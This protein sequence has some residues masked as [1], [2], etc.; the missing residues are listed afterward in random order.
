MR[1]LAC[2]GTLL[3]GLAI[4]VS[5]LEA[6]SDSSPAP[7]PATPAPPADVLAV[8]AGGRLV[9]ELDRSLHT[10]HNRQGDP[11][12]F[13]ISEEILV[14]YQVAVPR[15]ST[16]RATLTEVKRPGRLAGRAEI[17]LQFD[18]IELPD[19]TRLPFAA[20]ILRAGFSQIGKDK[21]RLS[22]KGEGNKGRDLTTIGMGGAQGAIFGAAI[23][24]R[25]GAAYG[26]AVGAGVGL[27]GVLLE[28]GPELDLPQGMLFEV[29]LAQALPVPVASVAQWNRPGG[30]GSAPATSA[31]ASPAGSFQFPRERETAEGEEAPPE[32]KEEEAE[33]AAVDTTRPPGTS[34][35]AA[36]PPPPLDPALGDPDAYRMRVDVQ[37]VLVEAFVRD[38]RGPVDTLAKEDF[39][40]F[41]NGVEQKIS[42]FSRDELPL[43]VA[44]V[45]DRS[46]SVAPYM[47][48]LRRAA[49]QALSQLKRGDQVCL[50]SF[51]SEVERLE[52]LTTD[53]QRIADRI[54]GIRPGGG[55]N[56]VDAVFDAAYYLSV[57]ARD[58][59][60]AI[61]L[62]SDNQ[63]TVR[64]HSSQAET[65]RLALEAGV[66]VYSLKTPGEATPL[67]MKIPVWLGGAGSVRRI[68]EETGGEILDVRGAGSL[69]AALAGV[70]SRLKT[71]YTLGYQST[72]PARDGSFRKIDLTLTERFGRP[73]LN[74]SV[75]AR[76][77]YYAPAE[78]VAKTDTR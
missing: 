18:E 15:G 9:L 14:G 30:F 26:G 41:E 51:A 24:G 6:Q 38:E 48:A 71:R 8:P 11:A 3:L 19:G 23:G 69:G 52:D 72:N 73:G 75:H 7:A 70:I 32:F 22:V 77:G 59:R 46:G 13:T 35:P 4:L 45:V 27:L 57:A 56:I 78:T 28:R 50:F 62:V 29:E 76:R 64:G 43:A 68:T 31:A 40:L 65:I 55:T 5:P 12:F 66:T 74:Y 17:R 2:A 60:R 47:P 16:V 42:H 1:R 53:R 54:A 33:A 49:Y 36:T 20:N 21:R 63:A 10:R 44:L 67:T 34:L 25:K 37:L 61:I 39:R 58:R